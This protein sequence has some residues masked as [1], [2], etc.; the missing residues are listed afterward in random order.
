MAER[1]AVDVVIFAV[2]QGRLKALLVRRGAPPFA[3]RWAVPGGFLRPGE[4]LEDAARRELHEGTG[5]QDVFLEQL[6]TFGDPGRDPRGHVV[7]VSYLAVLPSG[8]GQE[9]PSAGGDAAEAG[10]FDA[11][12]PPPLAFDHAAILRY[13][14]K[15]LRWKL[16]WTTAG[17]ALVPPRFT[18]G[19]LQSAFEAVLGRPV[20]KRNFRRKVLGLGVLRAT[21]EV[22]RAGPARPSRTFEFSAA[23]FERLRERG[24]LFPF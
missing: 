18:L 22:R 8:A 7:S 17:F 23:R 20:D 3:G 5:M 2:R 1:V 6:Y 13:A 11:H 21:S 15:R 14:L 24:V 9:P 16:E 4:G 12:K 19:E 10:W